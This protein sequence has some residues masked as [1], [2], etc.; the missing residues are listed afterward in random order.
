MSAFATVTI[1]TTKYVYLA[2]LELLLDARAK[3]GDKKAEEFIKTMQQADFDHVRMQGFR[4]RDE[5]KFDHEVGQYRIKT[6]DDDQRKEATEQ[7]KHLFD[8]VFAA[9]GGVP[10]DS[11]TGFDMQY[12]LDKMLFSQN[13]MT[14]IKFTLLKKYEGENELLKGNGNPEEGQ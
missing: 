10:R 12:L 4:D 5:E 1:D 9:S 2:Y 11:E 7:I 8:Q 3:D 14:S 13:D 6:K